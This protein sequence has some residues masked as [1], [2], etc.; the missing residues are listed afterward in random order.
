MGPSWSPGV[1]GQ[2][3]YIKTTL[4]NKYFTSFNTNTISYQPMSGPVIG[5]ITYLKDPLI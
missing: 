4:T 3:N 2:S 1:E 5:Y